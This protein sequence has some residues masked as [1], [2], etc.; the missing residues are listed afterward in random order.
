ML[1]LNH[2]LIE[3]KRKYNENIYLKHLLKFRSAWHM[4]NYVMLFKLYKKS[5]QMS[6]YLIDLFIERERKLALKVI[7]KS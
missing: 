2:I 1:D 7:I 6:K 3:I 5:N 4:N